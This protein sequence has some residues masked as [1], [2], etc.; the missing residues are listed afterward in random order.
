M[1]AG[2]ELAGEAVKEVGDGCPRG[3]TQDNEHHLD[4]ADDDAGALKASMM[5]TCI[6]INPRHAAAA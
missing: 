4:Q 2:Q 3:D 1:T 5:M 6:I